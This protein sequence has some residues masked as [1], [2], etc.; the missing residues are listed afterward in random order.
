MLP[1]YTMTCSAYPSG[2]ALCL[3][4]TRTNKKAEPCHCYHRYT[5]TALNMSSILSMAKTYSPL[6]GYTLGIYPYQ[7]NWSSAYGVFLQYIHLQLMHCKKQYGIH[8][9]MIKYAMCIRYERPCKET[10]Y[11]EAQVALYCILSKHGCGCACT[12]ESCGLYSDY[13]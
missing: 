3:H 6:L 8:E 12:Q 9:T 11:H 5:P 7:W 13:S 1:D 10:D 2:A 4:N